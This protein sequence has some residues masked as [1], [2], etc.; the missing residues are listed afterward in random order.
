MFTGP[1]PHTHKPQASKLFTQLAQRNR[2]STESKH[3][4]VTDLVRR[5]HDSWFHCHTFEYLLTHIPR[6]HFLLNIICLIILKHLIGLTWQCH[7]FT[8]PILFPHKIQA[9]SLF[10]AWPSCTHEPKRC[11]LLK[12]LKIFG[13]PIDL[14]C[15]FS[16]RTHHWSDL[17]PQQGILTNLQNP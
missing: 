14:S 5:H 12:R 7:N 17:Q 13:L 3:Y 10:V 1:H 2:I 9:Y 16:V 6:P 11:K 4:L 15:H 8:L